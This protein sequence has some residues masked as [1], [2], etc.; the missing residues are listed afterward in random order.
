MQLQ[1]RVGAG[2][3]ASVTRGGGINTTELADVCAFNST[4]THTLVLDTCVIRQRSL[5]QK[6]NPSDPSVI[7][8]HEPSISRALGDQRASDH[9]SS[10]TRQ[11]IAAGLESDGGGGFWKICQGS[12]ELGA[13]SECKSTVVG[14][15]QTV[16]KFDL[17][18]GARH[19]VLE[20]PCL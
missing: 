12:P 14:S 16:R 19:P 2:F 11:P 6:Q 7:P 15:N 5:A 18:G 10:P 20:L 4:H 1:V 3:P 17:H 8:V 13:R 9:S